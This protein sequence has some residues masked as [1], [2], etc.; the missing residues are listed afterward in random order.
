MEEKKTR[1]LCEDDVIKVV[2]KHT[3]EDG[4]LDNDI[5]CILEEIKDVVIVGSKKEIESL[6]NVSGQTVI[7]PIKPKEMKIIPYTEPTV[8]V[9]KVFI[10]NSNL[11]VRDSVD[12][13]K[14]FRQQIEQGCLV[15]PGNIDFIGTEEPIL[16]LS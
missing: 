11:S 5:S 4:T 14:A 6:Q 7:P 8:T 1:L 2:D 3:R 10:F 9:P 15:V 16:I 13:Q 12:A